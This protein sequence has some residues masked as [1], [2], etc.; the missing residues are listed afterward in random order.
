MR[1]L[2]MIDCEESVFLRAR[3]S[4]N[5]NHLFNCV[6]IGCKSGDPNSLAVYSYGIPKNKSIPKSG[7]ICFETVD[8][9]GDF[10]A[11]ANNSFRGDLK[12]MLLITS[13][14]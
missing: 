3:A 9:F 1:N 12:L 5:H 13:F 2:F 11:L 7:E 14:S 6:C 8:D 4:Q 10:G